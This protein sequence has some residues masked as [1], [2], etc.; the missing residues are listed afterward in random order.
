M[1]NDMNDF[2]IGELSRLSGV[3]VPNIRYYEEVG[4]LPPAF[5]RNGRHRSYNK[6]D[7]QRLAFVKN[8][9]ELGFPI[10]QIRKLIHLTDPDNLTCDEAL[11]LSSNQLSL[12][13]EKIKTLQ[14]IEKTLEDHVDQC[15][16]NCSEGRAPQC[17]ILVSQ[18]GSSLRAGD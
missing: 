9:R 17:K 14:S 5:R 10:K 1:E 15:R 11:E 3:K 13:K 6:E 16:N 8:S 7:L 12:V 2:A 18:N 4:I